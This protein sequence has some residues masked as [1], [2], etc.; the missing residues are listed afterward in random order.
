MRNLLNYAYAHTLT[1]P[2]TLHSYPPTL[3][4][5]YPL[6]LP[7]L[8]SIT[9]PSPS[10][11]L[12]SLSYLPSLTLPLLPSPS[13]PLPLTFLLL[14]S[15]FHPLLSKHSDEPLIQAF[16]DQERDIL[17]KASPG[18]QVNSGDNAGFS[19]NSTRGKW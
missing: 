8:L 1:H 17:L 5:S 7:I 4:P 11:L 2:T 14:P 19:D 13:Y 12:P 15:Q 3:L 9:Y 18:I 6:S 16:R 10:S